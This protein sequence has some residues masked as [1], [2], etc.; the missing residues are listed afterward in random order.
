MMKY[1]FGPVNSRRLGVSLGIDL[2]PHKTCSLDCIYCECGA[3][4][5]LTTEIR[6]YVPVR[7]VLDELDRFLS[8]SPGLDVITFSGSGEP[9]LH[10]GIGHIIAH[11]KKEYPR[12]R[13]AVLTN[14]TLLWKEEVRKA[15]MGAHIVM[16]SLDAALPATFKSMLKPHPEITPERVMEG[17]VRFGQEYRGTLILE[18]FIIPGVNTSP[19]DLASLKKA[20]REIRHDE[21]Q[22]NSLDRPGSEKWI[23]PAGRDELERIARFFAPLKVRI[24]G[25]PEKVAGT[26]YDR[27]MEQD[28]LNIIR[29]RPSTIHELQAAT[30]LESAML[31]HLLNVMVRERCIVSERLEGGVFYRIPDK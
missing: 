17:L 11:L 20:C 12:Y 14:G 21:I 23:K 2:L 8:S 5:D 29:R 9:T 28:I 30:G 10:S 16:P 18:V 4:T 3:T 13:I 27:L 24:I 15:I 31:T 22:L 7:E 19:E 1:L 25:R 26:G 6:E